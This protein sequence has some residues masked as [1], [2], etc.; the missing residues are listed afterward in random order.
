MLL[1]LNTLLLSG[2]FAQIK[3]LSCER[4]YTADL[5]SNFSGGLKTGTLYLGKFDLCLDFSSQD[6]G[7]WKG[8]TLR[9]HPV[10]T[11]GG[12]PSENLCGDFQGISNI[13]AGDLTYFHELWISQQ[14]NQVKITAGLQDLNAEFAVCDAGCSFLNGSFGVHSTIADNIPAPIFPLTALGIQLNWEISR[15]IS[16]KLAAFDG[17]P[18]D[19]SSNPYNTSWKLNKKEGILSI[20]ETG[21]TYTIRKTHP[22]V[23]KLGTYY[24]DHSNPEDEENGGETTANYGAYLIIDQLLYKNDAGKTIHLFTQFSISPQQRNDHCCYTG[25]G[26]HVKSL[27]NKR[28][29]DETGLA[30]AHARFNR[31]SVHA[32][33]IVEWFYKA[34]IRPGFFIQPDFQYIVNPSGTDEALPDAFAGILRMG[35]TF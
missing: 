11:H 26:V 8:T 27:F 18:E 32:E 17:L 16:L 28:K 5:A 19:F 1:W 9:I 23:L 15:Q 20:A 12:K 30:V 35:I 13:E 34:E 4:N 24:H 14:V 6:A 21:Y 25:A 31:R 10:N 7:L 33:T 22:G 2:S 3:G 29:Q